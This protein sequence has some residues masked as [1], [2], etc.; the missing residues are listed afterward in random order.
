MSTDRQLMFAGEPYN[1]QAAELTAERMRCR[2]LCERFNALSFAETDARRALLRELI[3]SFGDGAE[4]MAPFNCDYGY[5]ITV[6]PRT[7]LNYGAVVLDAA[8]VRI[9]ADVQIGPGVQLITALHPLNSDERVSGTETAVAVVVEDRAW[10]AAGVI[11]LPGV[12][13]GECAVIGAGSVVT[14]DQPAGHLCL[15]SPCRPIRRI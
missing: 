8:E 6:G 14:R 2:L 11:V 9:G 7:F 4:V 15:G 13:I 5:R 10:L 1:A 12:T 3:G